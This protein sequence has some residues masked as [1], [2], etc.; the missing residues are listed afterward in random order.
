MTQPSA[1][2]RGPRPVPFNV[3]SSA[4]N[5]KR[6]N[7]MVPKSP[8]DEGIINKAFYWRLLLAGDMI[9]KLFLLLL[10]LSGVSAPHAGA[11]TFP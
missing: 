7:E 5:F 8:R 10:F 11:E 2:F 3:Q 1:L 9:K 4:E 6:K